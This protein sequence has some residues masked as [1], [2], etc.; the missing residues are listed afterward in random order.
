MA[1]SKFCHGC[2]MGLFMKSHFH[3]DYCRF[4]VRAVKAVKRKR[5]EEPKEIRVGKFRK[6]TNHEVAKPPKSRR[7]LF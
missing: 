5:E 6:R 7:C 2:E 3:A 4:F 1:N